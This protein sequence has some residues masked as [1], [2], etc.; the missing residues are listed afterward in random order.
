M[1]KAAW[2]TKSEALPDLARDL[3]Y[4]ASLR[5]RIEELEKQNDRLRFRLQRALE[6]VRR[7]GDRRVG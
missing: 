6:V 1:S 3:S 5:Q 2:K 7:E 4:V